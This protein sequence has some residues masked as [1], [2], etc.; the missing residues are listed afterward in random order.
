[1]PAAVLRAQ[2]LH[3][4]YAMIKVVLKAM[5]TN[6]IPI[7]GHAVATTTVFIHSPGSKIKY[8]QCNMSF[9]KDRG[10]NNCY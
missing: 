6:G 7:K 1:M 10:L 4:N 2:G 3:L 8:S 5:D 9:D